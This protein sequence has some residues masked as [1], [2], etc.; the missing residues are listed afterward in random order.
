MEYRHDDEERAPSN[1]ITPA[2]VLIHLSSEPISPE[3]KARMLPEIDELMCGHNLQ[4][5]E[6]EAQLRFNY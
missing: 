2:I 4:R 3:Q 6:A 1:S 5:T